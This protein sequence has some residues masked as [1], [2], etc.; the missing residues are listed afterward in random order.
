MSEHP[1]LDAD[2]QRVL[3]ALLEKQVTVPAS[4][5][6]SLNGLRT[7]CNQTTSRDPLTEY[8]EDELR[9]VTLRL[10]ERHLVRLV[11]DHGGR[12]VKY[13]QRLVE[14][15]GA[16]WADARGPLEFRHPAEPGKPPYRTFCGT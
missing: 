2:E 10:Q 4:Y 9:A 11:R 3:G 13:A 14:T 5:P 6:L 15:L 16:P 8:S 7:A 1:P 12:T